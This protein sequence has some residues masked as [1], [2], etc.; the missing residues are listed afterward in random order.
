MR[1]HCSYNKRPTH[2]GN[3]RSVIQCV[4]C[5]GSRCEITIHKESSQIY[6]QENEYNTHIM[7]TWLGAWSAG[8]KKDAEAAEMEAQNTTT[9][10]TTTITSITTT[11]TTTTTL[12]PGDAVPPPTVPVIPAVVAEEPIAAAIAAPTTPIPTEGQVVPSPPPL[13][14]ATQ[15]TTP[16][17]TT[18]TSVTKV[19]SPDLSL[20]GVNIDACQTALLAIRQMMWFNEHSMSPN[21]RS[22]MRLIMDFRSR[23]K[24]FQ[25]LSPWTTEIIVAN[26]LRTNPPNSSISQS[27]RSVFAYLAYGVLLP[28]IEIIDPCQQDPVNVLSALSAEDR[29]GVTAL[30]QE[31]IRDIAYGKWE[32]V[33]GSS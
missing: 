27:L 16:T 30:A 18:E 3:S 1:R 26:A 20:E 22:V 6:V 19:P 31:L 4:E 11:T 7:V 24:T 23:N 25:S 32:K 15:P 10:T 8:K 21:I 14:H 13:A 17:T 28:G 5:C 29:L 33:V 2:P 12:A 9:T